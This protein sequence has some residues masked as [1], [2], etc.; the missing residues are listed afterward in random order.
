MIGYPIPQQRKL[1]EEPL[2][3]IRAALLNCGQLEFDQFE[4][5]KNVYKYTPLLFIRE[6][7]HR[8]FKA[9]LKHMQS[10]LACSGASMQT[11]RPFTKTFEMHPWRG[12]I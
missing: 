12:L 3:T 2:Q 6:L 4:H 11:F 5:F 10:H 1:L 8:T 9:S 7:F